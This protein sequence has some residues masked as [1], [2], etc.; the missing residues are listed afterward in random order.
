MKLTL[1]CLLLIPFA[2]IA[3]EEP[4][5]FSEVLKLE[6]REPDAVV[7]YGD[8][9]QQ[10]GELW[11]PGESSKGLIVFVHGGCWLNQFDVKHSRPL[12]H[13]LA[14]D[15]YTVWSLEYR[16][17]GDPG[18]GIP[19][20]FDDLALAT[21]DLNRLKAF[22]VET[23]R[24]LIAGHSAGG[25]L[26]LWTSARFPERFTGALGMAAITDLAEY[27]KGDS[28]CEQAALTL[29]GGL[30]E[31]QPD[32]YQA[33]SPAELKLHENTHLIQGKQDAIVPGA[34]SL[35]LDLNEGRV[36]YT[37]GGHF[38]L[39]HPMTRDYNSVHQKIEEILR[40]I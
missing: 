33:Y 20:T 32:R 12:A 14:E 31:E 38:D 40:C 1:L 18:A 13:Q 17:L 25:H 6:V 26:A 7:R 11:L 16:R 3:N 36:S 39:M 4:V 23:Q 5:T 9:D 35:A 37:P 27:A 22:G 8:A 34:Q 21:E 2:V 30:S 15:G 24:I 10:F 29:M 28:P 19:G